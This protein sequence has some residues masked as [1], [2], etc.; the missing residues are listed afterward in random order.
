MTARRT[1]AGF[2]M[3][4]LMLAMAIFAFITTIMWGT[5]SQTATS[6]R[7]IQNEQ[8]RAHTV[9]VA[10]MRMARELEM[11]YLSDNENTAITNRRTFFAA[12]ARADVDEVTF[13][14]FAHQ[15]LR[16]GAA[17]A[18]S[19]LISYFGARDPDDRRVVNLMRRETR[20]LQAEDPSTL[21]GEAYILCPDVARVKFAF[22]DHRKKEWQ[23][24]W[25]TLEASAG[26]PY[27]PA[28]VRITLTVIDERGKEVSYSTDA[29]IQI[30][31]TISYR[32]QPS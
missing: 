17:E 15:R 14:T 4:E 28:H 3:I 29:R 13:S 26:T 30:T 18:D 31:E 25:T 10:L 27:L 8:E 32:P 22:Y 21:L 6:K 20:R 5:F 1:S 9:R 16:A 2:T 23:T 11:A 12:S 19:S 24:D 7:A